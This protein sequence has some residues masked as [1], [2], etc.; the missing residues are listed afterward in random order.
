[1]LKRLQVIFLLM[2]LFWVLL[3]EASWLLAKVYLPWV[4]GTLLGVEVDVL[5]WG[6]VIL[7]FGSI[8]LFF[9][10]FLHALFWYRSCKGEDQR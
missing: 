8:I 4:E 1:M 2:A 3:I 9:R 5:V 10:S 7:V 6:G